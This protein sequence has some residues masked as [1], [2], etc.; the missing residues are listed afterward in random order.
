[1]SSLI[2]GEQKPGASA[3][4]KNAETV[5]EGITVSVDR[6]F[7]RSSNLRYVVYIYNAAPGAKAKPPADVT[8]QTQIFRDGQLVVTMPPRQPSPESQYPTHLAYAAEIPLQAL[9]AGKY[10][11]Q[12]TATDRLTKTSASQSVRFEVQ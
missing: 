6:R 9:R 12:V 4:G 7:E 2:V 10:V 5:V 3:V 1:M 8:L 11:L